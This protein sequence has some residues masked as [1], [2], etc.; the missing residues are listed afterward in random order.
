[1]SSKP[2]LSAWGHSCGPRASSLKRNESTQT[3]LH[4]EVPL[5]VGRNTTGDCWM[6]L[7]CLVYVQKKICNPFLVKLSPFFERRFHVAWADLDITY[8]LR[9]SL[10]SQSSC[11]HLQ[12]LRLQVCTIP[13]AALGILTLQQYHELQKCTAPPLARSSYLLQWERAALPQNAVWREIAGLST[14][15]QTVIQTQNLHLRKWYQCHLVTFRLVDSS[16]KSYVNWNASLLSWSPTSE[17]LQPWFRASCEVKW[18]KMKIVS[19]LAKVKGSWARSDQKLIHNQIC[20]E[21]KV[22]LVVPARVTSHDSKGTT[23]ALCTVCAIKPHNAK[24]E[25]LTRLSSD[26]R[27][28]CKLLCF[29]CALSFCSYRYGAV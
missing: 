29:H 20:N 23:C 7:F 25:F 4:C 10:H 5:D 28:L 11:L 18:L 27:L 21:S 17:L 16:S 22:F 12:A 13:L 8:H 19:N 14:N 2:S 3:S 26:M 6:L 24:E 15:E 1:M 9:M